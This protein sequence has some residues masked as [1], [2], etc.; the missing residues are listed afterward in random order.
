MDCLP[1]HVT[2]FSN[3]RIIFPAGCANDTV[4]VKAIKMNSQQLPKILPVNGQKIVVCVTGKDS[5]WYQLSFSSVEGERKTLR[6]RVRRWTARLSIFIEDW[7]RTSI[8]SLWQWCQLSL[9]ASIWTDQRSLHETSHFN[10][11][12]WSIIR[13][14]RHRWCLCIRQIPEERKWCLL[15]ETQW[16]IFDRNFSQSG[17]RVSLFQS[18]W[19]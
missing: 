17:L 1:F 6:W 18:L 4:T 9:R 8:T 15:L 19:F 10:T 13:Q 7:I 14:I 11:E 5:I 16:L 12:K 2:W 3:A